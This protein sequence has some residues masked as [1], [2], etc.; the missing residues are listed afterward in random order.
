V[1]QLS[2]HE[3][4]PVLLIDL[5]AFERIERRASFHRA[6]FQVEA[7]VVP[8]ASNR[9]VDE[10]AF[11]ERAVVVSAQCRNCK[12]LVAA[13]DDEDL[14]CADTADELRASIELAR[15]DSQFQVW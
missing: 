1:R 11:D 15:R 7:G 4:A 8:R 9:P 12:V 6:G 13:L 14:L 5:P 10:Q 3:N 2:P